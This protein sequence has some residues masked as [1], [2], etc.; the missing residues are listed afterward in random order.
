MK[1]KDSIVT[2]VTV[3]NMAIF[4][5][6]CMVS[7]FAVVAVNAMH[8]YKKNARMM[9]V[10]ISSTVSSVDNML[11]DMGRVS[12]ICFSDEETQEI[13]RNYST[14]SERRKMDSENYLSQM[15]TSLI[16]I[17]NDIDGVYMFDKDQLIFYQ[18]ARTTSIRNSKEADA[19]LEKISELEQ[20]GTEVS[21]CYIFF[22]EFPEFMRFRSEY[23]KKVEE[24]NNIY[25]VRSVR[26]FRPHEVIGYIAIL[27]SSGSVK[28]V[29]SQYLEPDTSYVLLCDD[30]IACSQDEKLIGSDF[31]EA[32]ND[33]LEKLEDHAGSFIAEYEERMSLISYKKSD[34]SGMILLTAKP[35]KDIIME[36]RSLL[37]YCCIIFLIFAFCA[38]I[39]IWKITK[40]KL[41]RI[42]ELA[43]DVGAFDGS[44][45]KRRYMVEAKDEVG[46]LKSSFNYMLDMLE[47]LIASEYEGKM[48][49]QQAELVEQ[50]L[51][52]R[53]LKSQVNP[54]FLYN[55]LDMIRI[56]AELNQDNEVSRMLMRLVTFYR[57]STK[58]ESSWVSLEHE[59][60]MLDAYMTLM[61]YRYREL[62]YDA[63]IDENL[64]TCRIPNF[65]LQPLVEN[66]VMHGL[67]DRGYIGCVGL[68][69]FRKTEYLIL[70]IMDDGM[71]MPEKM[72]KELNY[73]SDVNEWKLHFDEESTE[74]D[75][76]IGI[77]NV[78]S[79]LKFFYGE[80]CSMV[81]ANRED[82]GLCITITI[83][84]KWADYEDL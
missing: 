72:L 65:I 29:I 70:Q 13:L 1:F 52:M 34:Y 35:L 54:H 27:T 7:V 31:N 12:L 58:V 79:R 47:E 78:R 50:T 16:T 83:K 84:E 55:T 63:D 5:C 71:G 42:T 8:H 62:V 11:K 14:Y 10:Y 49:L 25:L 28:D 45:M 46:Q 64:L 32:E 61:C 19:F 80:D 60:E 51:S 82:G 2:K 77:V 20:T 3:V 15:Y 41:V 69:I 36:M 76:H 43:D 23:S 75:K 6:A 81:F 53:Y 73:D 59:V 22:D 26:S 37:I 9:D 30:M 67:K 21:G 66:S 17:R 18:D 39:C 74:K 48:K 33:L 40:K 57:L 44:D 4:L 68:K 38:L 56:K 24:K